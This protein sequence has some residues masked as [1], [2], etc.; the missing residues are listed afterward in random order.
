MPAKGKAVDLYR[1]PLCDRL[2]VAKREVRKIAT[3]DRQ[4]RKVEL[5]VDGFDR[6][7][8]AHIRVSASRQDHLN[9]ID[10]QLDL[11]VAAADTIFNSRALDHVV[12]REN[13]SVGSKNESAPGAKLDVPLLACF[14]KRPFDDHANGADDTDVHGG[15]RWIPGSLR[16]R[17]RRRENG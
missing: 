12:V 14:G 15:V 4:H 9:P 2:R 6:S 13:V 5:G 8:E 17:I 3:R 11:D 10:R 1:V 16:K 7:T